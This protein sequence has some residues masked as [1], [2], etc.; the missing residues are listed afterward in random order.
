MSDL[1]TYGYGKPPSPLRR[2]VD[3][4]STAHGAVQGVS[5]YARAGLH[6]LRSGGTSLITGSALG[7]I[8]SRWGLD[9]GKRKSV[10]IDGALALTSA[11]AALVLARDP[12]GLGVE[13]R[14]V[15]SVS[16]GVFAFRKTRAWQDSIKSSAPHGDGPANDTEDPI[17]AAARG[18]D[19]A[20]E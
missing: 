17:M 9:V 6:V 19:A 20:A 16:A 8:D 13:A 1:T 2:F 3:S 18:L 7:F 15:M 4:M 10:P 11:V 5:P 14:T 12:D